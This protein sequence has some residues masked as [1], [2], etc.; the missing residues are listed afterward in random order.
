MKSFRLYGTDKKWRRKNALSWLKHAAILLAGI[1]IIL[2]VTGDLRETA[3]FLADHPVF[4][5][6]FLAY[7]L[8]RTALTEDISVQHQSEEDAKEDSNAHD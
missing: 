4:I 2:A 1:T 5:I 8:A 7:A 6:L 3:E